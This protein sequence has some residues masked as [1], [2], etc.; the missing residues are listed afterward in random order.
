MRRIVG[1][2]ILSVLLLN[3]T[4]CGGKKEKIVSTNNLDSLVKL[5]PDSIPLLLKHG[6]KKLK[7]FDFSAAIDDAAKIVRLDSNNIDGRILYADVL[8]NR[9]GRNLSDI[10]NAQ[11]HYKAALKKQ[12]KNT[13][14]LIGMAATYSQ[15]QDFDRAFKYINTAL[16]IDPRYRDAYVLK[17]TLYLQLGNNKLA[18][19]SYETAVQQDPNFF[20]AYLRLGAI[21]EYEKN[22]ICIEYYRTASKLKP[23][24]PE[25]LYSLAYAYQ[26][27]NQLNKAK[28]VYKKML[29]I[30]S[31]YSEALFQLGYIKQFQE[32][33]IDSAIYFYQNAIKTTP[34]YVEAW[35]NLGLCYES[36]GEFT[37]ALKSFSK[38][39][40]YNP[41]FELSRKEAKHITNTFDPYDPKYK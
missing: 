29:Q 21:Y 4:S 6:E 14:A 19:S 35:H 36:Q 30:D 38:A 1:L 34:M 25:V 37:L 9:P 5:F 31:T 33:E 26:N 13:R 32:V 41:N 16:K 28:S 18:K 40:K 15:Q 7:T 27:F 11:Y 3:N 10:L 23:K 2:F 8:N 17:G 22:P 24:E 20:E 39:L 12:A